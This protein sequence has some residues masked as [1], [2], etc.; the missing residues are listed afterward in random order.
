MDHLLTINDVIARTG[1][2]TSLFTVPGAALVDGVQVKESVVNESDRSHRFLVLTIPKTI[3]SFIKIVPNMANDR[4]RQGPAAREYVGALAQSSK[5]ILA[6]NNFVVVSIQSPL[7]LDIFVHVNTDH[8][9]LIKAIEAAER[10]PAASGTRQPTLLEPYRIGVN[11]VMVGEDRKTAKSE[12]FLRLQL[13]PMRQM[14]VYAGYAALDF[15]NT[16]SAL[17]LSDANERNEF[18]VVPADVRTRNRD[19]GRPVQTALRI[20]AIK[21]PLKPGGFFHYKAMIGSQSLEE[22]DAGFF[23]SAPENVRAA[24]PQ[25]DA[26]DTYDELRTRLEEAAFRLG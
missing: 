22:A 7:K 12:R 17:V 1:I 15:G 18:H 16:S 25:F 3:G 23:F 4:Y 9:D 24:F 13:L 26:A 11:V 5:E 6:A 21:P 2:R 20:T 8:P 10:L 19:E 14:P